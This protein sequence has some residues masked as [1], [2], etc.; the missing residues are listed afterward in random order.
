MIFFFRKL[1]KPKH[2]VCFTAG[3]KYA[4]TL[5][6]AC[7]HLTVHCPAEVRNWLKTLLKQDYYCQRKRGF[8]SEQLAMVSMKYFK[9]LEEASEV[10]IKALMDDSISVIN[11]HNLSNRAMILIKSKKVSHC[12]K[13]TLRKLTLKPPDENPFPVFVLDANAIQGNQTGV[14]R[15]YVEKKENGE[16]QYYTVEEIAKKH[17]LKNG[18]KHG[19]HCEGSLIQNLFILLFWDVI[20]DI[21]VPGAFIGELQQLPLD[22][23][24]QDFYFNRREQID[25]KL[26]EIESGWS[27]ENL[28]E[29]LTDNWIS[30]RNLCPLYNDNMLEIDDFCDVVEC[31]GRKI[32]SQILER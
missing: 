12:Q 4:S 5:S 13:E 23:Y 10:I 9:D 26:K 32:F 3:H 22:F 16:S 19:I 7:K 28:K 24:N 18:Y 30:H 15:M 6:T 29:V 27:M 17:Y 25:L 11:Q 14:K 31:I 1:N 2:L 20:Y 21:E 8:W